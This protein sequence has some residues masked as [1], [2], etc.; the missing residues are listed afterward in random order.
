MR[1]MIPR[2]NLDSCLIQDTSIVVFDL[3]VVCTLLNYVTQNIILI[4]KI[5][6]SIE[7]YPSYLDWITFAATMTTS[8]GTISSLV[9]NTNRPPHKGRWFNVLVSVVLVASTGHALA[10]H[11]D[12]KVWASVISILLLYVTKVNSRY[13]ERYYLWGD[14]KVPNS[15]FYVHDNVITVVELSVDDAHLFNPLY[16]IGWNVALFVSSGEEL[17]TD[18]NMR[19]ELA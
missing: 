19:E 6:P 7:E 17:M 18:L 16:Q 1:Y 12:P 10:F 9:K 4:L 8:I 2:R 11:S 13:K 5:R 15:G 14:R 3:N